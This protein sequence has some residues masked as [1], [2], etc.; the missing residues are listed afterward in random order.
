MICNERELF[1]EYYNEKKGAG[2]DYAYLYVGMNKVL[3]SAGRV[4]RTDEDYG[5]ILLLDER[6]QNRQYK[7]LFPREWSD[8]ITV[9]HET[10]GEVVEDF[11]SNVNSKE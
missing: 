2:F 1:R 4:I 7:S 5:V 10:I 9:D 6:F 3:Q 11:W 8:S